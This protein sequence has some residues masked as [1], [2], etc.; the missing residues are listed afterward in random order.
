MLYVFNQVK[1]YLS[2]HMYVKVQVCNV[3]STCMDSPV[4]C[5]LQPFQ[6]LVCI[7]ISRY[8]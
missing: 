6:I 5:Q 1:G 8:V 3:Y 7:F 4:V 2:S